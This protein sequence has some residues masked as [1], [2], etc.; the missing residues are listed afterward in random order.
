MHFPLQNNTLFKE[1]IKVFNKV[2]QCNS[3][4]INTKDTQEEILQKKNDQVI[5]LNEI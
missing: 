4:K 3:F 2:K 5:K 1:Y